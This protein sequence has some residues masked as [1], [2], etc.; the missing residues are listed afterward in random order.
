ML[1]PSERVIQALGIDVRDLPPARTPD[2]PAH[3][4]SFPALLATPFCPHT[5]PEK[6]RTHARAVFA[7]FIAA[8]LLS[9]GGGSTTAPSPVL[10]TLSISFQTGSILVGQSAT[11]TAAGLDQF[12]ASIAT[13]T[14]SWSTGSAAV[15]T[16]NASGAVTGVA[17]GQTQVTATAGGKQAQAAVTVIP[18]PVANV[19]LSPPT[20][21][22]I[23]GT[24]QQ[25]VATTLDANNNVLT[26]RTVTWSSSNTAQATL[27]AN[28]LVTAVS[29]G[30][31]TIT[32]TS[33]GKTGTSSITVTLAPVATVTVTP[34]TASL[35]IGATQQLVAA[36][37]D[38]NGVVLNGRV[39]TW[40]TSDQ[41]KATVSSIGLVTAVAAGTATITATSEGKSGTA[42]IT[43]NAVLS[44]CNTG[45]A[46]QLA[47]GGIHPLTTAEKAS[48]CLGIGASASEYVLIPFNSTNVAASTIQLQITGTNTSAIQPGVLASLQLSRSSPL[49][50]LKKQS[51]MKSFEWA[52]RA[53]ERRDL[54][55][56]LAS[57][58]RTSRG[59]S[60]N[61]LVP[62]YLTGIPASPVV[63]SV[64]PINAN[65]S[66]NT[67][68]DPKQLHGA[69]VVAVLPHTIVLSDTLSPAGGFT[70]AE[71][72][73]FGQS[74]DTLGYALDI[75]N[76]GAPTDIDGNSRIA[77][78]FTPGVNVMPAPPG[79]VVGGEFAARD[80]FPVSTC[81][82]SNE[83][84]MFYMPVPDPNKTINANY[85][86]KA[87]VA[88][89][90]LPTL[91]HEFQH[92]I[93]A[94]RRVY[95]NNASSFEEVWLNEGLS[96]IAEELLYYRMSGNS[97]RS[98]INLSLLQ[99]SQAQLD[100][101]N[102]YQIQNLFRSASY[103][104]APETNS[105]FSQ[106]DLLET[107]G[108][109][110][111]L[112]RYSADRNG[113]SE[114]AIWSALVNT[115]TAGRANFNAVFGDIIAM[116]RDWVVAQFADDAGL[117]TPT[118]YSYPSWNF[119]SILPAINSNTYP[120]LTHPL[121]G[122]PVAVTLSGGGAAYLRFSVAANVPATI[123]A[124]SAG[125]PV[126]PAIDFILL[127]T[128]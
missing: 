75:L 82:A 34:A 99:S 57:P 31:P 84:E 22:L 88:S 1:L 59:A 96:H 125:Q 119:R 76:F 112:L 120:L 86:V 42:L 11:A 95:V 19:S 35:A 24:T 9:C 77:I 79:A 7:L 43:V 62:S 55:S 29:P 98:N 87:N 60:R 37:K 108:A 110:W 4:G 68:T 73:A 97:P 124:T 118:N 52:F 128:Q 116:S 71:M 109:I 8:S 126:P 105:P 51:P 23:V 41:T 56:A 49:V 40:A 117:G 91:V 89:T 20:A 10:T 47:V 74:F 81:V 50:G 36:L 2:L 106:V 46:L 94:G 6:M 17:P 70:N 66:G 111:Q 25:L 101:I 14:V 115:T 90:V 44:S 16:V 27:N 63:G 72:T 64:V 48:L 127:R 121:L 5:T 93:N 53:R 100:A 102:T 3:L 69:V 85:A 33:E 39:V 67:C 26:G 114:Q 54:A 80:L 32:A 123:G 65:I 13:G 30:T 107:R 113:G 38:V 103:M 18:V 83:G 21:T 15:A 12:G 104:K 78:L 28:G 92:L 122:A 61:I 58:R 45:S